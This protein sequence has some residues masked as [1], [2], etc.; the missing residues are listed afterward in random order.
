M[1]VGCVCAEMD[2]NI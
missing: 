2:V 1:K